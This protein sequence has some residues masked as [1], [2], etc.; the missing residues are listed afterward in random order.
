MRDQ[1][2]IASSRLN[3]SQLFQKIYVIEFHHAIPQPTFRQ[4]QDQPI[5]NRCDLCDAMLCVLSRLFIWLT[6]RFDK[7]RH[8]NKF[9]EQITRV[10]LIWSQCSRAT[11][12]MCWQID[13][14]TNPNRAC[15]NTEEWAWC[16]KVN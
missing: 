16:R 5:S 2:A 3:S 1:N 9:S 13:P 6:N 8:V 15:S 10:R 14:L 4:L 7:W 12:N 11:S